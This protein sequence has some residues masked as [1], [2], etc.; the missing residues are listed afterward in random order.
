MS[1]YAFT[2][3]I[4]QGKT[5]TWKRYVQEREGPRLN[6]IIR[7]REK[8]GL[9]TEQVW[10]QQTPMGD[11]AVVVWE[12]DNPKKVFDYFMKSTDPIDVWFR[13]KILRDCHGMESSMPL[14]PLN[15][16]VLNFKGQRVGEKTY[17]ETKKR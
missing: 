5:E 10:L 12:T 8:A 14:P 1:I 4:L 16:Q 15:E 7:S 17:A 2:V 6:D 11:F 3:P 9:H 13:E